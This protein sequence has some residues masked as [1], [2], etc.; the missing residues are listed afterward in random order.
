MKNFLVLFREPDGRTDTHTDVESGNH[1]H[2][3]QQW[4]EK[5]LTEGKISGGSGLTMHGKLVKGI[6]GHVSDSIHYVGTEIVGGFLLLNAETLEEAAHIVSTCP[7]Y[8]FGG[9]AEVREYE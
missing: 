2:S 1:R 8:E 3:W 4:L 7:V 5:Y 9:Y 6:D